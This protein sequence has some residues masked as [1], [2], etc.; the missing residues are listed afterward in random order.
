MTIDL[1]IP[2]SWDKV[3]KEQLRDIVEIGMQGMRKEEYL[4]VLLCKFAN[5]KMVAGTSMEDGKKLV[6]TQFKDA[7]GHLFELEANQVKDFCERLSF[8]M[9]KIPLTVAWPFAWDRILVDTTFEHWF[10]ADAL[11]LR[12]AKEGE[13]EY[14]KK[15]T[16][17]LG[18][19][20][21]TLDPVDI[22][23]LLKWY[24]QFKA[25]LKDRYPL[26]FIEPEPGTGAV[27]S[28]P[29][30]TR[31]NILLMLNDN[32]PQD[33]ERI[34]QSNMHDVLAALQHKI[35]HAK[36]IEQKYHTR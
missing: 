17:E 3:T 6:H 1:H 13:V 7:E 27:A 11:M 23:L 32:R 21:E 14:L 20:R 34:E 2:T 29:L 35:E 12:F 16:K 8:V 5:I 30:D 24:E 15:V 31:Q 33:N 22:T 26:V 36:E 28:S 19:P 25:F 18:D 9:E 10:R 4:L